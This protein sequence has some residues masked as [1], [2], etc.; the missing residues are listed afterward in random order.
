MGAV[1]SVLMYDRAGFPAKRA[2]ATATLLC[3]LRRKERCFLV[4]VCAV[5]SV[6]GLPA[7]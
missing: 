2:A 7:P 1:L 5:V 3:H 4:V 6:S